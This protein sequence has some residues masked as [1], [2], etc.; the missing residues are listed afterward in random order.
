MTFGKCIYTPAICF[1]KV[2][3]KYRP[4]IYLTYDIP[5]DKCR[6][7]EYTRFI[8]GIFPK[9]YLCPCPTRTA[10]SPVQ[11]IGTGVFIAGALLKP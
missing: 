7:K 11:K 2:Y 5:N 9:I 4:D 8:L 1:L 6:H 10:W 3:T